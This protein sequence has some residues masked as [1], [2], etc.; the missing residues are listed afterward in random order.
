MF[1]RSGRVHVVA[2]LLAFGALAACSSDAA[3]VSVTVTGTNDSCSLSAEELEAGTIGFEFTN[4]ADDV[5]E[6]Y[7]VEADGDVVGEVENVTT[8]TT[9]TLTADLV[10]GDYLVRCKPGQSG[11]GIESSFRVVG[12]GGT[13]QAAPD[14]TTTF[15]AVEFRY[16]DLDVDGIIAGETIRFEMT[17]AGTQPHE[18]EVL[19]PDGNAIGEVAAVEPGASGGA[20]MTFEAPG[21]Y[22]YQCILVDENTGDQH[23]EL[24]MKGTFEVAAD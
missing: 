18:F 21:V 5:N 23:T 16:P 4:E 1:T 2:G 22:R 8:G 7:V 9:R 19:D 6:L 3:D 17:N 12:D 24:G 10:A 15:E 20:T 14:R 11:D 13:A